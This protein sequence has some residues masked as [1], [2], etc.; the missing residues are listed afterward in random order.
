MYKISIK[1]IEILRDNIFFLTNY[2]VKLSFSH[3]NNPHLN[4]LKPY[5]WGGYKY[6]LYAL[7]TLISS[8]NITSWRVL[9]FGQIVLTIFSA[10]STDLPVLHYST[11]LSVMLVIVLFKI[12]FVYE[13]NFPACEKFVG[14]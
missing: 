11:I 14:I 12:K 2:E 7:V 6:S 4:H 1:L 5:F 9:I 10:S 13:R 3:T 8:P